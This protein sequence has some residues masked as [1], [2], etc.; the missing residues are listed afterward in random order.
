MIR[1]RTAFTLIELLV[2]IAIIAILAAILFPVFAQAK[3]AAKKATCVS[4]LKQW[5]LAFNMYATDYDDRLPAQSFNQT[6]I[7]GAGQPDR[8]PG[9]ASYAWQQVLQPYAERANSDS[10]NNGKKVKLNICQS[11]KNTWVGR[12]QTSAVDVRLSYGMV[13]WASFGGVESPR[14]GRVWDRFG[15]AF[16]SFSVFNSV[17]ETILLGEQNFNFNQTIYYPLDQDENLVANYSYVRAEGAPV[18]W[19]QDIPAF[20]A[21]GKA[22]GSLNAANHSLKT[23]YAF[24]DGHVK[25]MSPD[26]TYKMDGSKSM[27]TIS[28]T[29]KFVGL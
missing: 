1:N 5:G 23:N 7:N 17:A 27:W 22:S 19:L 6:Y 18:P 21:A 28:N 4:S 11:A 25:T 9:G 13:E 20:L 2:V 8:L 12:G 29:W 24:V 3:E 15:S 16:R 14:L 26:G 10:G